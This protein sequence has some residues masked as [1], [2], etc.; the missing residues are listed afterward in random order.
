MP[1]AN[2]QDS[3]SH[4]RPKHNACIKQY[5]HK[6]YF[7]SRKSDFDIISMADSL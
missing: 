1:L 2:P 4:D 6:I 7:F 3:P 5:G